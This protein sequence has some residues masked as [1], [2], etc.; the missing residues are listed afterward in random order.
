MTDEAVTSSALRTLESVTCGCTP[1]LISSLWA[2]G[3]TPLQFIA[4]CIQGN[5]N[6][7]IQEKATHILCECVKHTD[8]KASLSRAGGIEVLVAFLSSRSIKSS[9]IYSEVVVALCLCC[10][11]VHSRQ[12]MRDSNGLQ[13]LIDLLLDDTIIP[14]H[15]DILSA[16]ICYYFDENTLRYMIRHLGLMK[17]LVHHIYQMTD[18]LKTQSLS[19]NVCDFNLSRSKD[20]STP[21][22]FA[23]ELVE[24]GSE[25]YIDT[26]IPCARMDFQHQTSPAPTESEISGLSVDSF[27]SSSIPQDAS[28]QDRDSSSSPFIPSEFS[29]INSVSQSS[30]LQR[31]TSSEVICSLYEPKTMLTPSS[32][33][34]LNVSQCTVTPLHLSPTFST[35]FK[36]N[37]SL[38]SL[39]STL[40]DSTPCV[41]SRTASKINLDLDS[42]TPMPANFIDSLLASPTLYSTQQLMSQSTSPMLTNNQGTLESKVLLLLS[43]LSHLHDCQPIL[44]SSEILPAILDYFFTAGPSNAHCFKVLSRVFS[45]PHCFQDC[46]MNHAPSLVFNHMQDNPT[47]AQT[48]TT[49]PSVVVSPI[50]PKLPPCPLNFSQDVCHQL[51]NTLCHVAESPYG[52]GVIAHMLLRGDS[53]EMT[54]G[55]LALT[56]L[57][58]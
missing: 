45:N 11:D 22:Y 12:K 43:R 24:T 47:S 20:E 8:G 57:Q 58:R 19:D 27:C 35:C 51:F 38:A 28:L 48:L 44:A 46:L 26:D 37:D 16:L 34:E 50:S 30:E 17:S 42:S 3:N 53:R 13:I 6:A 32:D 25:E 10:R 21:N 54:A 40:S 55:C 49:E 39:C 5:N 33:L 31:D 29:P 18:Q 2:T 56:L 15:E 4:Q 52:Q 14:H 1:E 36:D 7:V 41:T 9:M 23:L